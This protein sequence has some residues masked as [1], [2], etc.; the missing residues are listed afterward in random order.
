MSI[1]TLIILLVIVIPDSP[2][3][4]NDNQNSNGIIINQDLS[5]DA[6]IN[7]DN[8]IQIVKESV[9]QDFNPTSTQTTTTQTSSSSGG[10]GGGASS[11]EN[12][13]NILQFEQH[14]GTLTKDKPV[15]FKFNLP[16]YEILL[17]GKENEYDV[18]VRVELL[19]NKPQKATINP[20]GEVIQ[21]FNV[22][23][24]SKRI[25]EAIIRF[26]SNQSSELLR[27][28]NTEWIKPDIIENVEYIEL[29]IPQECIDEKQICYTYKTNTLSSFAI[30]KKP[31]ITTASTPSPQSTETKI[32]TNTSIL[33]AQ[34]TPKQSS[35]F[36]F[37]SL[38][39]ILLISRIKNR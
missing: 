36:T 1:I 20:N 8:G 29:K 2:A 37:I 35:G 9:N 28:N 30:I 7:Y 12:F 5:N 10:G 31:I 38:I 27:W 22:I 11:S 32:N 24:S 17:T 6:Q 14:D 21:Y 3:I 15:S 4:T 19:K 23:T 25:K 18:S 39:I 13:S 16:I 34:K 26:K 33:S